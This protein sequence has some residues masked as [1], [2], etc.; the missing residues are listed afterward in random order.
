PPVL[1]ELGRQRLG[2]PAA[3]EQR[4]PADAVR[5]AGELNVGMPRQAPHLRP[6]CGLLASGPL[7]RDARAAREPEPEQR[8]VLH[9]VRQQHRAGLQHENPM[10][11]CDVTE[12]QL[13]RQR[14]AEGPAAQHD[15]IE[16][17]RVRPLRRTAQRL[18]Q[19]VAYVTAEHVACEVS[20]LRSRGGGHDLLLLRWVNVTGPRPV[21]PLACGAGPEPAPVR[22]RVGGRRVVATT[23]P[24]PPAC[25]RTRAAPKRKDGGR[26]CRLATVP[27]K[28]GAADLVPAAPLTKTTMPPGRAPAASS[29]LS[30]TR[31]ARPSSRPI[32][33]CAARSGPTSRLAT[34]RTGAPPCGRTRNR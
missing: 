33:R 8:E 12:E 21:R 28:D 3:P 9:V 27:E 7:V 19:P 22:R 1:G 29:V 14:Q 11:V 17:S 2:G 10:P 31:A 13:V 25:A 24:P 16:R 6:Q 30:Y 18:V 5:K 20:D 32:T 23:P 4:A 15:H 34:T 26:A